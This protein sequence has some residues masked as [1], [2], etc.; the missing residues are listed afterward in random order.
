MKR[1]VWM[2]VSCCLW[3]GAAAEPPSMVSFQGK[4]TDASGVPV[5][6]GNYSIRFRIY[7]AQTGGDGDPCTGPCVWE[8]TQS[9]AT[10]AGIYSIFL[11][12]SVPLLPA[13][14]DGPERYVGVKLATEAEMV[15]RRR[16][17]STPYALIAANA[18]RVGDVVHS[19]LDPSTFNALSTGTWVLRDGRAVA[20]PQSEILTGS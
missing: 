5:A 10:Q 2:L 15:P 8:E 9:V 12:S 11:G 16:I 13:L 14:L 20:G 4:L 6:D 1:F 17:A 18:S 19:M 3:M 7:S